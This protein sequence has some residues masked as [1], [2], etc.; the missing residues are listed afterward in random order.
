MISNLRNFGGTWLAC[1]KIYN[2]KVLL[3][4][5]INDKHLC[6]VMIDVNVNT[7]C[8]WICGADVVNQM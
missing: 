2:L 4:K 7:I 1:K 8:K 3:M 6:E 5:Y